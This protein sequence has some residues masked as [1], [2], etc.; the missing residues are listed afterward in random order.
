MRSTRG[1]AFQAGRAKALLAV[2]ALISVVLM[3]VVRGHDTGHPPVH[4]PSAEPSSAYSPGPV[5]FRR[6]ARWDAS[7]AEARG[8]GKRFLR[9]YVAVLYGHIESAQLRGATVDLRRALRRSRVRVSPGRSGRDA[10]LVGVH[11]VRQAAGVVQVTGTVDDGDL[12]PYLVTAF[13]ELRDG[14]WR[15]THLADD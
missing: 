11:V 5:V 4:A 1:R 7:I 8:V 6:A 13:V 14:R 10:E 12:A 15:V 3:T 2:A 9:R